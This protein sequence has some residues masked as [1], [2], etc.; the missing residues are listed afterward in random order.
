[1]KESE[2]HK[3]LVVFLLNTSRR[4]KRTL[5]EGRIACVD[6]DARWREY[7]VSVDRPVR[8]STRTGCDE[9]AQA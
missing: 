1:L 2:L 4:F 7:D 3:I 5:R 6:F 8:R 9:F